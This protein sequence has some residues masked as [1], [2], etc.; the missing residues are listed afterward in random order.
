MWSLRAADNI[1]RLLWWFQVYHVAHMHKKSPLEFLKKFTRSK[2][3]KN[4]QKCMK[5][6]YTPMVL[7]LH[8]DRHHLVKPH[9]CPNC[10][11]NY[12]SPAAY[13]REDTCRKNALPGVILRAAFFRMILIRLESL[14]FRQKFFFCL[15]FPFI[16]K[17]L[18]DVFSV[19]LETS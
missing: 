1:K 13:Y 11:N 16:L 9:E 18:E 19:R 2:F 6:C 7:A 17:F 8:H 4:C 14:F 5:K 10:K 15:I 12:L 3:V